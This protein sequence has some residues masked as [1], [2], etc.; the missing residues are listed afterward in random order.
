MFEKKNI[1]TVTLL[2]IFFL[3]HDFNLI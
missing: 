1:V 3:T 2:L